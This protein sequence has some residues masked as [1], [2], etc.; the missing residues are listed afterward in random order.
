MI[1]W[2]REQTLIDLQSKTDRTEVNKSQAGKIIPCDRRTAAKLFKT[3]EKTLTLSEL[4]S[5]LN[6]DEWKRIRKRRVT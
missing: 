4:A 1:P 2:D 5:R 6:S 3:Y